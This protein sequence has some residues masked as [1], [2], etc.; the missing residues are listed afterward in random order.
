M[1]DNIQNSDKDTKQL[2]DKK[3]SPNI[4]K[5]YATVKEVVRA[6]EIGLIKYAEAI[7]NLADR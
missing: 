2:E 4:K 1:K 7:K 6:A 3:P 5:S